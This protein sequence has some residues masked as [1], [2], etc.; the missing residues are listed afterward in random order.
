M[1]SFTPIDLSEGVQEIRLGLGKF[2]LRG[3]GFNGLALSEPHQFIDYDL[4]LDD[5]GELKRIYVEKLDVY[6]DGNYVAII[7]V[8]DNSPILII[9]IL[10]TLA[11]LVGLTIAGSFLADNLTDLARASAEP[12]RE[13][14]NLAGVTAIGIL[15]LALWNTFY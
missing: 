7:E 8:L 4:A 5:E 11:G 6:P 14:S 9:S 15:I 10:G 3:G 2:K 13:A 1:C 12:I